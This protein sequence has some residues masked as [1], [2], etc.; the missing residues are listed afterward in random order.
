MEAQVDLFDAR[1]Q[2]A[3]PVNAADAPLA[4]V[5]DAIIRDVFV[6][7]MAKPG[8]AHREGH[9]DYCG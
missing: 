4:A 8:P 5:D 7:A 9:R 3:A 6:D 1:R 2:A